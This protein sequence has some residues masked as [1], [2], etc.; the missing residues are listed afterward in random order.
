MYGK[1]VSVGLPEKPVPVSAF[2]LADNA[3]SFSGSMVGSKKDALDMLDL[4]VKKNVKPWW[5]VGFS[6]L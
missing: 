4:A 5:V 3:S 6:H 1:F 2:V